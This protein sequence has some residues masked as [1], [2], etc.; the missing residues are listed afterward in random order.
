M[1]LKRPQ[2]SQSQHDPSI[3]KADKQQLARI[4]SNL[5]PMGRELLAELHNALVTNHN[6]LARRVGAD[7]SVKSYIALRTQF[8]AE[9]YAHNGMTP[10][11]FIKLG[12]KQM[13]ALV[14]VI[15]HRRP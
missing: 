2:D 9:L 1:P 13:V 7:P 4:E 3:P 5:T 14:E 6:D 10:E 8:W 15:A 12:R 11:E